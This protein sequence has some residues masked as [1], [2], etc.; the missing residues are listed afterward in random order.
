MTDV[1]LANRGIETQ[2]D[3]EDFLHPNFETG[4]HDPF[5]FRQ[6]PRAVER[7]FFRVSPTKLIP[8]AAKV[9]ASSCPIVTNC[10]SCISRVI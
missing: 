1:L 9:N 5:L 8:L 4:I 3:V 10:S 2:S 6:M 7:I